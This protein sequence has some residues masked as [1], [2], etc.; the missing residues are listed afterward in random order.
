MGD[1]GLMGVANNQLPPNKSTQTIGGA[2]LT[3][4]KVFKIV[5]IILLLWLAVSVTDWIAVT[6]FSRPPIFCIKA[7]SQS[8]Y[9]GLGYSYSAY[10]HPITGDFEYSMYVFGNL[11]K[12]TVTN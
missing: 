2:F 12:S 5:G 9:Y 7:S 8:H 4:K 6:G 11:V 1:I 3:R 10:A